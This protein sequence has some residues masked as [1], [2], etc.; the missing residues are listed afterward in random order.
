MRSVRDAYRDQAGF[1][2]VELLVAV[3]I[4]GFVA[5]AVGAVLANGARYASASE[6][7]QNLAHRGQQ[8][9]ER[10]SSLKYA[11]L[12]LTAAPAAGSSNL[13]N[14]L[15][16]F[17]A[18][19]GNYRWDRDAAGATT[20]EPLVVS[21]SQGAVSVQR[22]WSDGTAS[23]RI[24]AFVTWVA[25]GRCGSGCP[26]G[27]NYKRITVAVTADAGAAAVKP[28]YLTSIVSD[29]RA[30]PAGKIVNGNANPLADPNITCRDG[31]GNTVACTASVGSATVSEWYLSDTPATQPYAPPTVSHPTHPTVA[32]F[33]VCTQ[34][35]TAGCP[36]PDLLSTQA[37]PE[38]PDPAVEPPL[39][40]YS[41]EL[42]HVGY[43]GGRVLTR[44][45]S[46]SATPSITDNGKGAL[47]STAPLTKSTS[48]TGAGGMTL[49]SASVQGVTA[50]V[51]LCI[52][53]YDVGGSIANLI[54]TPP[55]RLGVVAYS[56]A[57]WP[58]TP[59]PLSFSFDFVT[60]GTINVAAGHRLGV[61]L[62]LATTS[63]SDVA[64]MYDHPSFTS[65][66]QLN[67]V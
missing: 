4:L 59:T 41:S 66:L 38:G 62:W 1:T 26:A 67:S 27:Q 36:V 53:I 2:I 19:T 8:E 39:L 14:P 10:L 50:S 32:P 63:Q 15:H 22:T 20:A 21:A 37:P 5:L 35:V 16:W 44:D 29:P 11:T 24:F 49:T 46:C 40:D 58:T 57:E 64:L 43:P 18:A 55:V 45:V 34:A 7:R 13:D 33:G 28:V 3:L 42:G 9:I 52:G 30:L 17:D 56:V 47:W 31:S 60:G 65:V 12:A 48:L 54:A 51:T 23:G 6:T 25:D 61:R